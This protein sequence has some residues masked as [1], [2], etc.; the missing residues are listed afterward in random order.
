VKV[1]LH[2]RAGE[3]NPWIAKCTSPTAGAWEVASRQPGDALDL[4]G[5]EIEKHLEEKSAEEKSIDKAIEEPRRHG[6]H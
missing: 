3:T 1:E 5:R 6:S 4:A 2:Y